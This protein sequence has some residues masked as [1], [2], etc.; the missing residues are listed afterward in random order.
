MKLI[1]HDRP[2][3]E[4]RSKRTWEDWCRRH[5]DQPELQAF[6]ERWV[7]GMEFLAQRGQARIASTAGKTLA[8]AGG[9]RLTAAQLREVVLILDKVWYLGSSLSLW[10]IRRG[11]V[12]PGDELPRSSE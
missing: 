8:D 11:I 6:A 4:A 3:V 5:A 7:E 1:G 10:A 9:E 2:R 12:R